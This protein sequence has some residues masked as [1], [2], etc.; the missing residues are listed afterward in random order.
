MDATQ[1]LTKKE[2]TRMDSIRR[3]SEVVTVENR[4]LGK[5]KAMIFSPVPAVITRY[6]PT[7]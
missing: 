6:L 3:L 1:S 4:E 7:Y 5:V 2:R